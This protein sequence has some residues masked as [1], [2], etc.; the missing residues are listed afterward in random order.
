MALHTKLNYTDRIYQC[1]IDDVSTSS[2]AYVPVVARGKVI[3]VFTAIHATVTGTSLVTAGISGTA[4]TGVSIDVGLAAGAV[5]S[6][7][8]TAANVVAAGQYLSATTNGGSTNTS[9][10][11]VTFV[12]RE[13]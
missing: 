11:T 5:A 9:R 13:F 8:P 10:C 3:N 1:E 12:V 4:I 7:V 6:D 2:T